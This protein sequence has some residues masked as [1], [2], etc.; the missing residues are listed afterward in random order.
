M[1]NE[2]T[3]SQRKTLFHTVNYVTSVADVRNISVERMRNES[4]SVKSEYLEK[5]L[6]QCH[7]LHHQSRMDYPENR[8]SA[9]KGYGLN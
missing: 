4:Y 7:F 9:V 6:F 3:S 1:K 8:P 2:C 5:D